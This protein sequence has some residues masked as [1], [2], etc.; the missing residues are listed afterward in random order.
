MQAITF[1][2]GNVLGYLHYPRALRR[3]AEHTDMAGEELYSAVYRSPVGEAY[4]AG[5]VSSADFVQHLREICRLTCPAEIIVAAWSDIF[6]PNVEVCRLVASLKGRFRL[7]LGSNTNELHALQFRRQFADTLQHF[8]H[9]VLSHEIGMCKP[10]SGFFEHCRRLADCPPEK[11]VFIDDLP[12]NVAGAR[13]CGWHGVLYQNFA[14]LQAQLQ[15][16]GVLI[17]A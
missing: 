6:Q 10:D 9:L 14:D 5:R 11:C 16:L 13:A 12:A 2:F 3:L 8:D 4:E 1:D 7:L 15:A 17:E